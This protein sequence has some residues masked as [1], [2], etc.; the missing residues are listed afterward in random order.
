ML[1]DSCFRD[2]DF[3][4]IHNIKGDLWD[5]FID[6]IDPKEGEFILDAMG[7]YGDLIDRIRN[8]VKAEMYLCD[9]CET[10]VENARKANSD[11]A[12]NISCQ[13]VLNLT[14]N[15]GFFDK[16]VCKMGL[17]EVGFA[18]QL[19]AL[20]NFFNVLKPGGSLILWNIILENSY[21]NM[22]RDVIAEKDRLAG[23]DHGV[24][25]R[26]FFTEQELQSTVLGSGFAWVEPAFSFT[27]RFHTKNRLS[28]FGGD[29]QKVSKLNDYIREHMTDEIAE[30]LNFEDYGDDVVFDVQKKFYRFL[31]RV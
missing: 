23:F 20:Q 18:Q 4:Q 27:H 2:V 9:L 24:L 26:Y 12:E 7:A 21:A 1:K 31:K 15:S 17:H 30:L 14:Y 11:I 8:R 16:V 5:T 3:K 6:V 19:F 25:N 13:S 29:M 10:D 22:F 28:E